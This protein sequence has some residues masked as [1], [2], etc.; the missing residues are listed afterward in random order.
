MRSHEHVRIG[1]LLAL[2]LAIAPTC[3]QTTIPPI[4]PAIEDALHAMAQSAAVIFSGQVIAVRRHEGVVEIDFAVEDAIRGVSGSAYTMR[5]WAGLWDST[6]EPLRIGQ[7]YLLL[8]H[9]LGPGGLSSPV[10]GADGAIPIFAAT[11]PATGVGN[12]KAADDRVIDLRWV[13]TRIARAA[14]YAGQPQA[15]P[16]SQTVPVRVPTHMAQM[17]MA[18]AMPEST[19]ARTG[20]PY[21]TVMG[22]LRGW[23]RDATR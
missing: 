11:P 13:E 16:A 3:A 5:E 15:H 18:T 12:S 14:E 10:G 19:T 22:V 23:E 8:L 7:R 20:T 21:S 4:A 17:D 1:Y 9:A 2:F 6:N